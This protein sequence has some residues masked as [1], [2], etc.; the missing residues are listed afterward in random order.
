MRHTHRVPH[1]K[2]QQRLCDKGNVRRSSAKSVAGPRRTP[3]GN[4]HTTHC[5]THAVTALL[6]N[7][8]A[9]SLAIGLGSLR[10][11]V[12]FS[13][14]EVPHDTMGP[15]AVWVL[16]WDQ[17]TRLCWGPTWVLLQAS[18]VRPNLHNSR[19]HDKRQFEA[20]TV[21]AARAPC[22]HTECAVQCMSSARPCHWD[23]LGP[24]PRDE[25]AVGVI[26]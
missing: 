25:D 11:G 17:G 5:E 6:A 8:V 19:G 23:I 10:A 4:T 12:C 3:A 9:D 16:Y 20:L 21:P 15:P 24:S 18:A 7:L 22:V 1:H 13:H 2:P 14:A 26:L